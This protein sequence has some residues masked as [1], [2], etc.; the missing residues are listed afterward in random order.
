MQ[1]TLSYTWKPVTLNGDNPLCPLWSSRTRLDVHI[2]QER[3]QI[4]AHS[5]SDILQSSY[6]THDQYPRDWNEHPNSSL[7]LLRFEWNLEDFSKSW[8]KKC[9]IT[10]QCN[11]ANAWNSVHFSKT[12]PCTRKRKFIA[13]YLQYI[14]EIF[15]GNSESWEQSSKLA[16][17]FEYSVRISKLLVTCDVAWL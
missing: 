5:M 14:M 8:Y 13:H 7:E 1:L 10:E 17:R 15:M 2:T 12:I 4:R 11:S 3:I 6:V 16:R 9:T